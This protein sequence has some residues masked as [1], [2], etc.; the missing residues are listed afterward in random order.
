MTVGMGVKNIYLH[1]CA[2]GESPPH[3]LP[4]HAPARRATAQAAECPQIMPPEKIFIYTFRSLFIFI[5]ISFHL[6]LC[7][8]Q[9]L[10]A[11]SQN[12]MYFMYNH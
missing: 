6:Y 2:L 3:L 8:L 5:Y 12:I 1:A 11:S 7:P 9:L 4:A 10:P